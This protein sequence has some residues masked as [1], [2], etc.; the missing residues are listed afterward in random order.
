VRV[1][2]AT[3]FF[4]FPFS[5]SFSLTRKMG[6]DKQDFPP[7]F[8]PPFFA[9]K[10][11]EEWP[12]SARS[13]LPLPF[14]FFPLLPPGREA[15]SYA[16]AIAPARLSALSP[17]LLPSPPFHHRSTWR[18]R[19]AP[20]FLPKEE[21]RESACRDTFL[22]FPLPPPFP[23]L[24]GRRNKGITPITRLSFSFSS[25]EKLR[26][27]TGS[28]SPPPFSLSSPPPPLSLWM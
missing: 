5:F 14:P 8:L 15:I 11:N 19:R 16:G 24:M 26:S 23:S 3:L 1:C 13:S 25:M 6:G 4:S 12:G 7:P 18:G 9:K 21:I 20:P 22:P 27:L 2:S 28:A 17:F 10:Q